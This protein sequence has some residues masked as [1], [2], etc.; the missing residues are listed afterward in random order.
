MTP[1]SFRVRL[2]Q[3]DY[4]SGDSIC[5]V[6]WPERGT[7]VLPPADLVI[8]IGREGLGRRVA[9][10]AGTAAGKAVLARMRMGS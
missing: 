7:G 5:L 9:L 2:A 3:I 10:S 8:T 6:E 4:F 1:R